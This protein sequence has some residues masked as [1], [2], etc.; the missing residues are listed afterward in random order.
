MYSVIVYS[1]FIFKLYSKY[2][3]YLVSLY[4]KYLGHRQIR[5]DY[6]MWFNWIKNT[7]HIIYRHMYHM[8]DIFWNNDLD[9]NRNYKISFCILFR[10]WIY[11]LETLILMTI[12]KLLVFEVCN[13]SMIQCL[14][15]NQKFPKHTI[16]GSNFFTSIKVSLS[17]PLFFSLCFESW[18]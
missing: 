8:Y 3:S 7:M 14:F 10:F 9:M 18:S 13:D 17:L 16:R 1:I 2:L 5:S 6:M 11:Q 12:Y 15:Q 4:S